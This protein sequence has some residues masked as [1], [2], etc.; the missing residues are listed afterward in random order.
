MSLH[1]ER[2]VLAK[3][4]G[5]EVEIARPGTNAL[6]L[7]ALDEVLEAVEP[8]ADA[9]SAREADEVLRRL[10]ED[11]HLVAVV[12]PAVMKPVDG[13]AHGRSQDRSALD[14]LT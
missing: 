10:D 13:G 2:D 9:S 3:A 4:V 7:R 6:G 12:L 5:D 1:R 14:D 8:S 11:G